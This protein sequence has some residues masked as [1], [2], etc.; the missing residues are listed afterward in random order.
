M[1]S[2]GLYD[3]A[4]ELKMARFQGKWK[5]KETENFGE[6][7]KYFG[8][9]WFGRRVVE[10]YM[11]FNENFAWSYQMDLID[12]FTMNEKRINHAG[13]IIHDT[14]ISNGTMTSFTDS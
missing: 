7:L 5:L 10:T 1:G 14:R 11:K 2:V 8:V 9:G 12:N 6:Y 3:S 13:K 4:R